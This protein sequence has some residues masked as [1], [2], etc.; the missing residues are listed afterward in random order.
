MSRV[1]CLIRDR[2]LPFYGQVVRFPMD[3][4]AHRILNPKDPAEWNRRRERPTSSW[5][6]QFG[7]HMKGMVNGPG[8]G[9][10]DRPIK[11]EEEEWVRGTCSHT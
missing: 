11:A 1:T 10:S 7:D 5:L 8:A 3:D 2:Q 6:A 4:I 9:P